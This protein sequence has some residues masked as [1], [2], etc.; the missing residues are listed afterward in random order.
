MKPKPNEWRDNF[1]AMLLHKDRG[2]ELAL[3]YVHGRCI[4][5]GERILRYADQATLRKGD[6]PARR[7][8]VV[9]ALEASAEQLL[10]AARLLQEGEAK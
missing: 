6:S 5:A 1:E 3:A 7:R 9:M 4:E 2:H 10:A 8:L